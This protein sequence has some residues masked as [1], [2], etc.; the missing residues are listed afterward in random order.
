[1]ASVNQRPTQQRG[2]LQEYAEIPIHVVKTNFCNA[3]IS[4]ANDVLGII[5]IR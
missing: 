2:H 4:F 1:M 3:L 5:N